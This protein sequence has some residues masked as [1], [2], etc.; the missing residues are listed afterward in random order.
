MSRD[1]G[2]DLG[3][4]NVLVYVKG[5]GVVIN[6][7]SVI[8]IN[9]E[10]GRIAAV[11]EE[12]K[13]M[14]GR[15][16]GNITAIRPMK[17]GVIADYNTTAAM[18]KYFINKTKEKSGTL[19]PR[20]PRVVVCAPSGVTDVERR[21]IYE[22]TM[23]AGAK[24]AFII[25]EPFAAAIGARLPVSEAVGSMVVDIGG[26]TTEVAIISLGGIVT[27]KSIRV[28]GDTQDISIIQYIRK[29]HNLL[30][31]ERTAENL[32]IELGTAIHPRKPRKMEVRGRDLVTG[33]PKLLEIFEDEIQEALEEPVSRI[34][35]A[36][37]ATLERCPPELSGDI[38][39]RGIILTG[40]GAMLDRLDELIS[41]ETNIPVFV[42]E[43]P[44]DCVAI[45]TGRSLD[46]INILKTLN[47]KTV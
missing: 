18:L 19:F 38:I 35:E 20:K 9:Q 10:N 7:P 31:G 17:D 5:K 37:K 16:P 4:A 24:E 23:Q 6:E 1:L 22:A 44:L 29:K 3:T 28:G 40:G 46:N 27:S 8:A 32:K 47:K 34:V 33:L 30:I 25:E 14:V 15:T 45:G 36:V 21:A 13:K 2:I 41:T 11:G 39:E 43:E 12:A 42:A 26:G